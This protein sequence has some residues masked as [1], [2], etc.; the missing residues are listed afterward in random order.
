ML[1][2]DHL[3]SSKMHG[4]AYDG[5]SNMFGKINGAAAIICSFY[6]AALY[7]HHCLNLTV[8]ALFEEMSVHNMTG[9]KVM[10]SQD[11]ISQLRYECP[12]VPWFVLAACISGDDTT[13]LVGTYLLQLADQFLYLG[14]NSQGL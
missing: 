5:A 2:F 8:V 11:C 14:C 9:I 10:I 4:Q 7:T 12:K 3:D 6:P 13:G 1:A